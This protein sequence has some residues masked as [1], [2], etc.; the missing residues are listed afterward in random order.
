MQNSV[1]LVIILF[2]TNNGVLIEFTH[3]NVNC[4]D[5]FLTDGYLL[6][7]QFARLTG[8]LLKTLKEMLFLV[9]V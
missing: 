8:S 6:Y 5:A 9:L 2:S 1:E 4:V 7:T 3:V